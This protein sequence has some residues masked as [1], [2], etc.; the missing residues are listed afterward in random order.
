MTAAPSRKKI[1]GRDDS[2]AWALEYVMNKFMSEPVNPDHNYPSIDECALAVSVQAVC[3]GVLVRCTPTTLPNTGRIRSPAPERDT[4]DS[5]D[6]YRRL[7][8]DPCVGI[9]GYKK[10]S[11]VHNVLLIIQYDCG[12][13]LL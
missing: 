2:T 8:S 4:N 9:Q 6:I 7:G 3:C 10:V 13:P 1:P 5:Q 12:M 11:T